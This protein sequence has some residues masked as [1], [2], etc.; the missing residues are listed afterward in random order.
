MINRKP[1]SINDLPQIGEKS[2]VAY[3]AVTMPSKLYGSKANIQTFIESKTVSNWNIT[4]LWR[5][6]G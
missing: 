6:H 5:W 2:S 3:G 1:V 4:E